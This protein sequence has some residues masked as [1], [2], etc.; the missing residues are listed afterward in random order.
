L[1]STLERIGYHKVRPK[2]IVNI[3]VVDA[4]YP[5]RAIYGL[6]NQPTFLD[7]QRGIKIFYPKKF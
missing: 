1:K 2:G 5:Q 6:P 4:K 7:I 3:S